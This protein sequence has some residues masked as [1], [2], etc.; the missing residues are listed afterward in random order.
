ML[1][2]EERRE[3]EA[4]LPNYPHKHNACI[5]AL[6]AVQRHRGWI[7]DAA[8]RDIAEFLD[9]SPD[10]VDGV[11]TFY[12]LIFRRPVG[13]HVVRVCNSVSC[14][15]TGYRDVLAHLKGRLG[16][17]YAQTTGDGRFTLLPMECL[18][19]CDRAPTMMIDE[20]LFTHLTREK[21]DRIL[22]SYREE[23]IEWNDRL[24]GTSATTGSL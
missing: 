13:R 6:Q 3:I 14:W 11:A 1:T 17:D 19:A 10:E 9:M 2:Q 12:N 24:P 15:L 23:E 7:S 5:D 16:I 20:E 8:I 18:G 4:E 22:Q 21:I